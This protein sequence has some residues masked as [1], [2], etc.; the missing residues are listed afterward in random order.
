MQRQI[1][2]QIHDIAESI[3]RLIT[4][5]PCAPHIPRGSI[6]P[7]YEAA[8]K[9]LGKPLTLA[10][11]EELKNAC[12]EDRWVIIST[13]FVL[14]PYMPYGESDGPIGAVALGRSLN[15]AFKCKILFLTEKECMEAIRAIMIGAGLLPVSLNVAMDVSQSMTIQ[16]FPV[17]FEEAKKETLRV[18]EK[19]N[20]VAMVTLEKIGRNEKGVYHTSPGG[21]MSAST[22][23]VDL[24]FDLLREKGILT[25]GIGDYGNEMGLGALVDTIKKI[26]PTA[27]K[28]SCP[29]GAGIGTIVEAK[30]PVVASISNWGAYGICACLAAMLGDPKLLHDAD[31]ERRMIEQASYAGL[32]DGV[33][34]KPS[35]SADG[36]SIHGHIAMNI[37]LHELI[38]A[39][40]EIVPF[41]RK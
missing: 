26:A 32:C 9:L 6:V 4:V 20:P 1:I 14:K 41:V 2:S 36:I 27:R 8:V 13:G 40:T 25:I 24:L 29:C 39:K 15:R 3:D 33:T 18:Y 30:V 10:A 17:D 31:I 11:S 22:A 16:E 12:K 5:D 28:C 34:V 37:L 23:K 35:F 19:F 21:D 38:R 7:L